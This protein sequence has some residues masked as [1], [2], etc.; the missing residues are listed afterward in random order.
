[1]NLYA[2]NKIALKYIY[3]VKTSID[4]TSLRKLLGTEIFNT[5]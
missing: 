4:E 2:S 3:K 1:M 5:N